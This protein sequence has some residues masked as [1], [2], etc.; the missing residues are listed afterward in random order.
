M[1]IINLHSQCPLNMVLHD[2][3]V[4]WT[5]KMYYVRV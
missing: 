4:K 5:Y 3:H 2:V 1:C